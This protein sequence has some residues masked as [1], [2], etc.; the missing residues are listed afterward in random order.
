MKN[1][2]YKKLKGTAE[3]RAYISLGMRD[4]TTQSQL[5]KDV[6][7]FTDDIADCD[8]TFNIKSGYARRSYWKRT[9]STYDYFFS[10]PMTKNDYQLN[11][12][13]K[14]TRCGGNVSYTKTFPND[15]KKLLITALS[16][17]ILYNAKHRTK[18][19]THVF[20][21]VSKLLL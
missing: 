2:T 20:N 14:V 16:P 17:A 7:I 15:I 8:Y 4:T 3:Y 10:S 6:I 21:T 1:E 5:E 18:R 12:R 19:N 9:Y 11:P 13:E